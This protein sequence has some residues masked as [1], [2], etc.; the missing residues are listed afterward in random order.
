[1]GNLTLVLCRLPWTDIYHI[2]EEVRYG[3]QHHT[4]LYEIGTVARDSQN[5]CTCKCWKL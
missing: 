5:T 4:V 2:G 3:L 1:M